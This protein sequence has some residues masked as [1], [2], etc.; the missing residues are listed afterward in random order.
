[1]K[2]QRSSDIV[3]VGVDLAK[4]VIQVHAVDANGVAVTA[5]QLTREAFL[6]WCEQLPRQCVVAMEACSAA[7]H[8]G[9]ALVRLGLTP[10]LIAPAF[11]TPYRMQGKTAKNDAND[12]AAVCEA[13]SR[14]HMRFVPIKTPTQQAILAIH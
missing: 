9:R 7:H 3:R 13:A 4:S 6:P 5:K 10:K 2:Q 1:M 14:P 11:V 12:A 8:W